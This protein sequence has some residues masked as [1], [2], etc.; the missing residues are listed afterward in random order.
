MADNAD[1]K[2]PAFEER[3]AAI[4]QTFE[5]V[6]VMQRDNDERF[7]KRFAGIA[8]TLQQIATNQQR[9]GEHILVRA[10]IAERH[11]RRLSHLEGD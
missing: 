7:E 8:A 5:L 4:N 9:D 10:R 6:A 3:L 1:P 11:G 2:R